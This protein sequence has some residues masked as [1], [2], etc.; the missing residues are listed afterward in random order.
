MLDLVLN[1]GLLAISIAA[2][3]FIADKLIDRATKLAKILGVSGAVIGLTLLAYGTSVPEFAVSS[4]ASFFGHGQLSVSNIIGSNICNI[5]VIMGLAALLVPLAFKNESLGK[6]GLFMVASTV[7]LIPLAF[8]GGISGIVGIA[9]MGILV[10]FTYYVIKSG[11]KK[12]AGGRIIRK[13]KGS[14]RKEFGWCILFLAGIMVS[15]NFV[16][17]FAVSTARLAGV[18]EWL[19]GSTIVAIGTSVPEI[20]VS[21]ISAK[22]KQM[23]MSIGNIIGS[24]YFNILLI[25]GFSAIVSPLAFSI[26][27]IWIDLIFLM[28]ITIF[29]YVAL[30]KRSIT[31]PEGFL[32]ISIYIVYVLYLV[33]ILAF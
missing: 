20:V 24:N 16:V 33:K 21:V 2:L 29:F 23:G 28:V 1:A 8:L 10:A 9:M 6:D 31:R 3:I 25:L 13:G 30:L 12:D 27:E 18:T 14:A 11:G 32:Y 26:Q 4:L 17:Q 7:L 5:A 22:K 19:I 15:G